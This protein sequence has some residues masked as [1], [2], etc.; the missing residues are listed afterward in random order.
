[1]TTVA[2]RT[3][4]GSLYFFLLLQLTGD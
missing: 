3:L 4:E 1:M 2:V